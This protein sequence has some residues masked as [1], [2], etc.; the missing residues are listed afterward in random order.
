M[1]FYSDF[2][3]TLPL[4]PFLEIS[5]TDYLEEGSL[6]GPAPQTLADPVWRRQGI[7]GAAASDSVV[8][9]DQLTL[10]GSVMLPHLCQMN[11]TWQQ[12][13]VCDRVKRCRWIYV[14]YH[15]FQNQNETWCLSKRFLWHMKEGLLSIPNSQYSNKFSSSSVLVAPSGP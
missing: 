10:L 14:D 13:S 1:G 12:A 7:A 4:P 5:S 6:W 9:A 11:L 3:C 2:T 15:C 8:L